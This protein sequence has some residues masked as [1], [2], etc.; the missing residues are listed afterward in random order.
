MYGNTGNDLLH[1]GPAT[2]KLSGR[3]GVNRV[4]QD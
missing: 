4:Y 3:A 2:D 1:G